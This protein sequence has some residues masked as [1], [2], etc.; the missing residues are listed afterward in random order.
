MKIDAVA[1]DEEDN[2]DDD[3]NGCNNGRSLWL[4]YDG[5]LLSLYVFLIIIL[6]MAAEIFL[7]FYRY[8]YFYTASVTCFLL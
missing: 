3:D 8:S 2:M 5:P 6:S 7:L 1:G 4:H